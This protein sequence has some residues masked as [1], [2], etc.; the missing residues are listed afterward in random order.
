MRLQIK[1]SLPRELLPLDSSDDIGGDRLRELAERRL[2]APLAPVD[3]FA[4]AETLGGHRR[5][6]ALQGDGEE[7]ADQTRGGLSD[8]L[9]EE[10]N[11]NYYKMG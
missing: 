4:Q 2:D 3:G 5:P 10:K 9:L 11:K 8:V 7:G 1:E 6:A